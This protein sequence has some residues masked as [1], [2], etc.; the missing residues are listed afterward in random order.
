[1]ISAVAESRS[2]VLDSR[3]RK[4]LNWGEGGGSPRS[5]LTW[6]EGGGHLATH[7]NYIDT[8]LVSAGTCPVSTIIIVGYC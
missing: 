2:N 5:H 8:E 6:G 1:M 7:L 4:D 3:L